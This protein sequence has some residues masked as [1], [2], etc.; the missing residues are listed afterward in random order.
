MNCSFSPVLRGMT[1]VSICSLSLA[2]PVLSNPSASPSWR[3]ELIPLLRRNR[4][5]LCEKGGAVLL[6]L[7][8][9]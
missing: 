9:N 2:E 5:H 1:I 7:E 8:L 6:D 3:M 4:E